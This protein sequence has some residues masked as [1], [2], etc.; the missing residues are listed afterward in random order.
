M[1][2]MLQEIFEAEVTEFLKRGHYERNRG[3]DH[4]RYRQGYKARKV[5]I[6]EGKS[7]QNL[8]KR[9]RSFRMVF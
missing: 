8:P 4:L 7:Q 9:I 2:L 5:K 1:Q 3:R 6:G